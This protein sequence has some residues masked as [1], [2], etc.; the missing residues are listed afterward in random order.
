VTFL[1]ETGVFSIFPKKKL[2]QED[3]GHDRVP[4]L[5]RQPLALML[6]QPNKRKEITDA[7]AATKISCQKRPALWDEKHAKADLSDANHRHTGQG[8][9]EW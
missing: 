9:M 1:D 5:L 8:L 7:R 4:I 2:Q 3:E 6:T